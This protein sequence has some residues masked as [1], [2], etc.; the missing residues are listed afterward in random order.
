MD[1]NGR[2]IGINSQIATGGS[3][4][5]GSVGI[6]FAIP[7]NTAKKLLPKLREGTDIKRAYLGIEMARVTKDLANDLNLASD[8]GALITN[9]VNGGPAD[10]AGLHGGR[11]ETSSGVPAGGDLI[12]EVDGKTID[13]PDDVSAAI[14]SHQP[15]DTVSVTY[16][17]GDNKHTTKVKLADRPAKLNSPSS[18]GGGGILPQP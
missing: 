17:R 4:S 6:G 1:A 14:S 15:G 3:G 8:K 16:Y 13:T 11:T 10:K 7:I 18:G 12:V 2:V 9:V 5:N